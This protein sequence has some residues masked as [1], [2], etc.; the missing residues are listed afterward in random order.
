[1]NYLIIY[2][3]SLIFLFCTFSVF[4]VFLVVLDRFAFFFCHFEANSATLGHLAAFWAIL[5]CFDHSDTPLTTTPL[6]VT[7]F[8]PTPSECCTDSKTT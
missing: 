3:L 6:I 4:L 5:A 2:V 7:P 8:I 1:M